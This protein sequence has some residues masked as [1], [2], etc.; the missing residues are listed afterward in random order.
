MVF[1]WPTRLYHLVLRNSKTVA[2][3]PYFKTIHQLHF[4]KFAISQNEN[5]KFLFSVRAYL[6]VSERC[7]CSIRFV[8]FLRNLQQQQQQ[9]QP[10]H[11]QQ[12]LQREE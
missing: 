11:Q 8:H 12:Q 1:D 4:E 2:A 6:C 3:V 5:F 10:K 7:D 9:Q